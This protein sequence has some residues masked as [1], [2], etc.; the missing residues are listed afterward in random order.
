MIHI[1]MYLLLQVN[2]FFVIGGDGSHRGA[3]AVQRELTA[4]QFE[5]SVVG[6][7]KTI[8][9]DIPL[10]DETFGFATA[11]KEACRAIE[12]AYVEACGAPNCVGLVKLMGRHRHA[13][14]FSVCRTS[15][16][17]NSASWMIRV[18]VRLKSM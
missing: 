9:N 16:V 4:M 10:I 12:A 18:K 2:M 13:G 6:I 5:C 1:S 7:P 8:D 17:C 11:V 3:V 15:L 14:C